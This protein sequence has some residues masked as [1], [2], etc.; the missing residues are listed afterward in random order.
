M[1]LYNHMSW[2]YTCITYVRVEQI[3]KQYNNPCPLELWHQR[4]G[5]K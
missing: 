2:T 1:D 3:C 4:V 5:K